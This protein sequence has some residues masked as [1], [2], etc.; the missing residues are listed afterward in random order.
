[1]SILRER[2]CGIS[3]VRTE[4]AREMAVIFA[5]GV[6]RVSAITHS[7]LESPTV[8]MLAADDLPLRAAFQ[9]RAAQV[10]IDF[11]GQTHDEGIASVIVTPIGEGVLARC[12]ES[13]ASCD[14]VERGLGAA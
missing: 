14:A 10:F 12:P 7:A 5:A 9:A 11:D 6:L 3:G 13:T 8:R 4:L 2:V 1:M